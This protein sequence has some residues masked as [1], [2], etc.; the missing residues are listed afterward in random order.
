[1]YYRNIL[2]FSIGCRVSIMVLLAPSISVPMCLL[3]HV[4]FIMKLKENEYIIDKQEKIVRHE[5]IN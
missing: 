5:K 1:M 4:W 3:A 2:N